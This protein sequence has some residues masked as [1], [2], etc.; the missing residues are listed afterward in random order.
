MIP[1]RISRIRSPMR[2]STCQN[3]KNVRR[4]YSYFQKGPIPSAAGPLCSA[5]RFQS[6]WGLP[7]EDPSEGL[8]WARHT[9]DPDSTVAPSMHWP[10]IPKKRNQILC[11]NEQIQ[12][13][14]QKRTSLVTFAGMTRIRPFCMVVDNF[15]ISPQNCIHQ[16]KQLLPWGT[17]LLWNS[18]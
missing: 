3:C 2:T 9:V 11:R 17:L 5:P 15:W 12:I 18:L 8:S 1:V 6:S 7:M 10:A 14:W 13:T 16:T 4:G